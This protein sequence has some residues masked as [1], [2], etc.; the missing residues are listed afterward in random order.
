MRL[1]DMPRAWAR[2]C[3]GIARFCRTTL[4]VDLTGTTLVLAYSTGLDSTALLYL[5]HALAP[6][7]NLTLIPAH[8]HHGLRPESDHEAEHAVRI[9]ASLELPCVCA[10]SHV[11]A[12]AKA[13]GLGL[14]ET[15]RAERYAFLERVRQE[16]GAD[17]IM[18][19][20]HGD[21]LL[22]DILLRLVRGTGWPGLGGMV[23]V[24]HERRILRPLLDWDKK[25]VQSFALDCGLSWCEDASNASQAYTRNRIRTQLVPLLR[26]ENP[27]IGTAMRQ[28]WLQARTDEDYWRQFPA[29]VHTTQ[30]GLMLPAHELHSTHSAQR[31]RWYKEVLDGMGQGQALFVQLMALDTAW[32]NQT[33][34][35][36]F[37]FPGDKAATVTAQGIVFQHWVR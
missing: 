20:H 19:A 31:L 23:G 11:A 30:Q 34:G 6:H 21:D 14:E 16:H 5:A 32:D 9:C 1:Q 24:D 3:L 18:T 28:L 2:R 25:D 35:R 33:L 22:E 13:R 8:L 4:D 15:S 7:L 12:L 26:A 36:C 10:R 29:P 37:Q 27:S 17:W